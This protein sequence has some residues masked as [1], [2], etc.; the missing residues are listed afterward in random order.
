MSRNQVVK[1]RIHQIRNVLATRR[2]HVREPNAAFERN[3]DAANSP[4]TSTTRV[5][6]DELPDTQWADTNWADTQQPEGA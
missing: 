1:E 2:K 3:I 5:D 4:M 6:I